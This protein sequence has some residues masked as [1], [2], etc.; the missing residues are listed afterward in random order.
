[1]SQKYSAY[2]QEARKQQSPEQ[3]QQQRLKNAQHMQKTKKQ[4]N[5]H[6]QEACAK[7]VF[8]Q[9]M[10]QSRKQLYLQI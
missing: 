5:P 3:L 9:Y 6:Q 1:M 10:R 8:M 4:Q 2:I 7:H